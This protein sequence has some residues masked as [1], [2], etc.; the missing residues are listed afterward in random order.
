MSNAA[1]GVV[2]LSK[3]KG[4]GKGGGPHPKV[5]LLES[6]RRGSTGGAF[7][8]ITKVGWSKETKKRKETWCSLQ[9]SVTTKEG[10][11]KP[12][13]ASRRGNAG[14]GREKTGPGRKKGIDSI[15][16]PPI[17]R[18]KGKL[19]GKRKQHIKETD[20]KGQNH[21]YPSV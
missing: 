11:T 12:S 19:Q 17:S 21:V 9:R 2:L 8:G 14:L 16:G 5:K 13:K 6:G 20:S 10:F 18:E 15:A 3:S 4:E 1:Q 7:K